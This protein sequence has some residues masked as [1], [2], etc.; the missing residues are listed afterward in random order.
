MNRMEQLFKQKFNDV[1]KL[2]SFCT[3]WTGEAGGVRKMVV[4]QSDR[5]M[6]DAG[7]WIK[8]SDKN[9]NN[10]LAVGTP[11]GIFVF[12]QRE[13]FGKALYWYETT[14]SLIRQFPI[15]AKD[16]EAPSGFLEEHVMEYIMA[17]DL[18]RDAQFRAQAITVGG[19]TV[20]DGIPMKKAKPGQKHRR[21]KPQ[22]FTQAKEKD[23]Q[24]VKAKKA[25]RGKVKED[26]VAPKK[27]VKQRPPAP[28]QK[29]KVDIINAAPR[30]YER[31]IRDTSKGPKLT[32]VKVGNSGKH[33][34]PRGMNS[35]IVHIDDTGFVNEKG[36]TV[37]AANGAG[38]SQ[39]IVL[40]PPKHILSETL[41]LNKVAAEDKP[42]PYVNIQE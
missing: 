2:I 26:E 30:S 9:G 13:L 1:K 20:S 7:E 29:A 36:Q 18:V 34:Q 14:R 22:A 32:S 8:T 23:K 42:E 37:Y 38:I 6:L 33:R 21:A 11:F 28:K 25:M 40:D 10:Y 5:L 27:V 3:L 12:Y 31:G 15:L 19:G 41:P 4:D 35:G 24:E 17:G 16:G 39:T